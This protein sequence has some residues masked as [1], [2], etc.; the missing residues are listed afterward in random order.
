MQFGQNRFRPTN[1]WPGSR[2]GAIPSEYVVA[3]LK[4]MKEKSEQQDKADPARS[5]FDAWKPGEPIPEEYRQKRKASGFPR[6][7]N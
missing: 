2:N 3:V 5:A 1:R 6:K 4:R 7:E